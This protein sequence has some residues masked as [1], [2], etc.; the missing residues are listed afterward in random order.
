M[1]VNF[2]QISIKTIYSKIYFLFQGFQG[3]LLDSAWFSRFSKSSGLLSR[4]SMSG[5]HPDLVFS[6]T[7]FWKRVF[8]QDVGGKEKRNCIKSYGLLLFQSSLFNNHMSASFG[9]LKRIWIA[10]ESRLKSMNNLIYV[11]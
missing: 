6:T 9:S 7:T 10:S 4:F 1:F 3:N 2:N 5:R 8:L 11:C